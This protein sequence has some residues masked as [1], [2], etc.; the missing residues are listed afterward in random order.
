MVLEERIVLIWHWTYGLSR[1]GTGSTDCSDVALDVRF[2][3]MW[4]WKHGLSRCGTGRT[5]YLD[6]VLEERIVLIW[7]WTY[8][9]SRCGTGST[10]CSDVALDVRFIQMWHWKHGLSRT[11]K[12]GIAKSSQNAQQFFFYIKNPH[13]CYILLVFIPYQLIQN[14]IIFRDRKHSLYTYFH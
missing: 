8:G 6:V 12:E 14:R 10:D 4:H 7:H 1:C 5:D 11:T 13:L 3:Q 2:I 9:L